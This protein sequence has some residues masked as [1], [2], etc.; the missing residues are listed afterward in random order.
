MGGA[1]G[2]RAFF[3]RAFEMLSTER[4][5]LDKLAT[6]RQRLANRRTNWVEQATTRL[7][8]EYDLIVLENLNIKGM[9]R[10]P[11]PKPDPEQD[12]QYLPNGAAAKAGLN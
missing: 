4:R 8:R 11:E 1:D 5:T 6:L 3:G 9:T 2:R 7:A 10:R 12:N